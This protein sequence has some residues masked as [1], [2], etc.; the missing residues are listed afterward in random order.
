MTRRNNV[1]DND[2]KFLHRPCNQIYRRTKFIRADRPWHELT[3]SISAEMY[4]NLTSG[5]RLAGGLW[6]RYGG[7]VTQGGRDERPRG[8]RKR[9]RAGASE[10]RKGRQREDDNQLADNR[11]FIGWD[12]VGV[13]AL[14][15]VATSSNFERTRAL[16]LFLSLFIPFVLLLSPS[17]AYF[18]P[19]ASSNWNTMS[20]S[21]RDTWQ[22]PSQLIYLRTYVRYN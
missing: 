8:R 19:R 5:I 17:R 10:R 12:F 20:N 2:S 21:E 7:C 6:P 9:T 16:P 22:I 4:S 11:L 18:A 15:T 1:A 13:I 14:T 3:L